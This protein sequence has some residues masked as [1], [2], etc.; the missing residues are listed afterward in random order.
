MKFDQLVFAEGIVLGS[1]T[2]EVGDFVI[3]GYQKG[4]KVKFIKK[5]HGKHTVTYNGTI[6]NK[7]VVSGFWNID[8]IKD[9]FELRLQK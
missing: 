7:N 4:T 6:D 3:N 8:D 5:Y 2:D 1:G 9:K